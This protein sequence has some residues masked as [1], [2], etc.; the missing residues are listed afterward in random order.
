MT[1]D[2]LTTMPKQVN[3]ELL[4]KETAA[5]ALGITTRKLELLATQGKIGRVYVP[6]KRGKQVRFKREELERVREQL[7]D[8]SV[9]E[10]PAAALVKSSSQNP[11]QPGALDIANNQAAILYAGAMDRLADAVKSQ[12]ERAPLADKLMLTL[13]QVAELSELPRAMLKRAIESGELKA[14]KTGRGYRVKRADLDAYI[15]KL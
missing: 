2:Q 9:T 11:A 12:R 6:G 5:A 7:A 8:E 4:D 15:K 10:Q 1:Q 14:I 3:D 13:D